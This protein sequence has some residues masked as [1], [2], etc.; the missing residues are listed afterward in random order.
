LGVITKWNDTRIA[1]L[2]PGAALPS[3]PIRIV[4]RSDGSGTTKVFTAY[5]AAVSPSWKERVGSRTVVT[6]PVGV[7]AEGS[8]GIAHVLRQTEGG[9]G[10]VVLSFA[11]TNRLK[12][13]ALG[14]RAG[15]F[16]LPSLD[17]TTEAAAREADKMPDDMRFLMVDAEG[18]RSYPISAF[19]YMLVRRDA[20]DE[21]RGAALARFLW[22]AI[23]DGQRYAPFLG[24]GTLPPEV[25][26]K[27]EAKVHA[28]AFGGRAFL[29][30]PT[31]PTAGR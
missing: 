2:N 27:A 3:T 22:W 29:P 4:H 11:R 6:W 21:A 14:N 25:V 7:G 23:H 10:Y 8:A 17:G 28:L 31:V 1:Y 26:S 19:S 20:D 9:V 13:A 30:T 16:V 12:V 24:Y 15:R 5:L 18:E